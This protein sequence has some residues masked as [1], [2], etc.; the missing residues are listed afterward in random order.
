[1]RS[2]IVA[3]VAK[4]PIVMFFK[5]YTVLASLRFYINILRQIDGT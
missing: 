4:S 3:P 2:E 1:M 5:E